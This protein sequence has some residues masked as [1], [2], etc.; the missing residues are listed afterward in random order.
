M[1]TDILYAKRLQLKEIEDKDKDDML[2]ILTDPKVYKSYMIPD[3]LTIEAKDNFFNRIKNATLSNDRIAYGIYLNNKIIGF[4]NEVE[5][6]NDSIEVGYFISS[7][8]WNQ[9]YASEA[10]STMIKEFFR[11]GFKEVKAGHFDFNIASAKV[12]IKCG[13]IK[14]EEEDIIE[15]REKKYKCIYY[16]IKNIK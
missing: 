8:Y 4:I 16:S 1:K 6:I 15:Y 9:G 14:T 5:R 7:L 2:S 10:L 12:M 3:L 11:L 13:M